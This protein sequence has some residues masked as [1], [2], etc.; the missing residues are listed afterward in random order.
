M[1]PSNAEKTH[2]Q[3]YSCRHPERFL[4]RWREFYAEALAKG[5][6]LSQVFPHRRNLAYGTGP[7]Q[8]LNLYLPDQPA[9]AP[10]PVVLF[11]HGGFWNEGHPDYY[12]YFAEHWV[13]GGAVFIS[14]G[15]R[16]EP[17]FTRAQCAEDAA[18]VLQWVSEHADDLGIDPQRIFMAGHSAGGHLAALASLTDIGRYAEGPVIEVAGLIFLS[19]VTDVKH[20]G[21]TDD[22]NPAL[23]IRRAPAKILISYGDPEENV[24]DQNLKAFLREG[25]LLYD[26]LI[27]FGASPRILELGDTD[28]LHTALAFADSQ[29][30]LFAA[31]QEL[32][33]PSRTARAVCTDQGV[34]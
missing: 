19:G 34:G 11:L 29:S 13:R 17:E 3:F 28:H 21:S 18:S 24:I 33:F 15:Y 2:E 22:L 32:V 30:E 31:A 23:W 26:A 8:I 6:A 16:K 5:L 25:R 12:D 20:W 27:K 10:R 1:V 14:A 4:P 7:D 9:D